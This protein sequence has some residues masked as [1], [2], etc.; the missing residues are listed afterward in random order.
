MLTGLFFEQPTS[1]NLQEINCPEENQYLSDLLAEHQKLGPFMQVLPICSRL[2]NQEILRVSGM[3]SNQGFGDF[4][5]MRHRSPSPM[6]SSNLISNVTGTGMGGWNGL[7]P[8][9][10]GGPHGMTMDWQG[11]PASPSS[12]TVKRILR[13]EIPVDTYPNFNFVGRL[14]GPRGNSLKRVEATTGCRVYIRGKGSIK[15]PD[16]EEK[17]R[18]RPGYE[19]LN[20]PLHILIEADL[21]ANVVDLRLRQAQEIIEELLKPVVIISNLLVFLLDIYVKHQVWLILAFLFRNFFFDANVLVSREGYMITFEP[22]LVLHGSLFLLDWQIRKVAEP[23]WDLSFPAQ[24]LVH[25]C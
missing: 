18:G 19:H 21:P 10:L 2:L 11:A 4:D 17:L 12:Y 20:E 7:P 8:E 15:D 16:K 5:R 22:L 9:R 6:A 23:S 25:R 3:M 13:L 24:E 14:L 1:L